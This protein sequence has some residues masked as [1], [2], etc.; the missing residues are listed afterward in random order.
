MMRSGSTLLFAFALAVTSSRA[1]ASPYVPSNDDEVLERL[2]W[3]PTDPS[4]RLLQTLRADLSRRPDDLALATR[5]AWLYVGQGRALSDPRYYGYA[6]A[7]LSPWWSLAEPPL[8]VLVLRATIRQHDH[9]FEASLRDLESALRIDPSNAQAW[10]TQAVVQQVRGEYADA[11]KSCVALLPLVRP[12]IGVTCLSSIDG[13]SGAADRGLDVLRRRLAQPNDVETSELLWAL[14]TLAEISARTGKADLAERYYKQAL[15]L[16]PP[17]DYLR[18]SYADF[19]LDQHRPSDVR[20]LLKGAARADALL[21]R[22]A[23][24]DRMDSSPDLGEHLQMLSDR[25]AAAR[26][27]GD[28]VHR[29]EEARFALWLRDRPTEAVQLA[30]ANWKVQREPA[31]ARILLESALVSGDGNAAGPVLDFMN[32][33]HIEDVALANL[34]AELRASKP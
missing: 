12:L 27:R 23:L 17:E 29:R 2:P 11:R 16:A 14:T 8:P 9:D 10:L 34:A 24:A 32:Q 21:L 26:A 25:F 1:I 7:A 22:L 30:A 18:A 28:S 20:D 19:L 31:D 4:A 5:A 33:T 15:A 6:Q 13:L 3:S